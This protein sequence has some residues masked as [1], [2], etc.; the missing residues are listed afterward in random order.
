MRQTVVG[1]LL[2]CISAL[3]IAADV[4]CNNAYVSFLERLGHR[5]AQ[6]SADNLVHMHRRALRLFDACDSGH[7]AHADRMFRELET[8]GGRSSALHIYRGPTGGADD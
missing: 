6:M 3:P 2:L 5:S 1:T 7:L 4:P 8:S